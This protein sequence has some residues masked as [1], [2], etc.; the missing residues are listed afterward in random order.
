MNESNL[1]LSSPPADILNAFYGGLLQSWLDSGQSILPELP[2]VATAGDQSHPMV[3]AGR[4]PAN[5]E[6]VR[7]ILIAALQLWMMFAQT[8]DI[9]AKL[10]NA[11][12]TFSDPA[13]WDVIANLIWGP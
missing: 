11:V 8:P 9:K 1:S 6:K 7:Y 5:E 13:K 4:N 3:R 10:F 12:V 2:Q